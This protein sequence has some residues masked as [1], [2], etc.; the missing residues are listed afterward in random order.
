MRGFLQES[1]DI[2]DPEI[3]AA[4]ASDVGLDTDAFRRAL[5]AREYAGR[6]EK[7]LR[8]A[9][10]EMDVTGVPLFAVGDRVLTALQSKDA[11]VAAI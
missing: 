8:H 11:L 7:L 3:L 1:R 4:L 10:D 9:H 2:G 5:D 6:V